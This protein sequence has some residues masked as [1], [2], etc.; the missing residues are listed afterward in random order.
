MNHKDFLS[1][2]RGTVHIIIH[3][4]T[5]TVLKLAI[6]VF[7]HVFTY[8]F[9]SYTAFTPNVKLSYVLKVV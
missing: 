8:T 6:M 2:V 7:V 9:T 1:T 5:C 4:C 3:F